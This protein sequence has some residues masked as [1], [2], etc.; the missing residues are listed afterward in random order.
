MVLVIGRKVGALSKGQMIMSALRNGM[1]KRRMPAGD[2]RS[3]VLYPRGWGFVY[4]KESARKVDEG[5]LDTRFYIV[6]RTAW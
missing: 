2:C 5:H 3:T 6:L 1:C 4:N